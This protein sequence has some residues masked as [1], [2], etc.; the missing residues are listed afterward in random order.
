LYVVLAQ[1]TASNWGLQAPTIQVETAEQVDVLFIRH[2]RL[3]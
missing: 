3:G 1:V 2:A